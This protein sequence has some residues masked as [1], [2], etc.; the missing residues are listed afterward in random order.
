MTRPDAAR[1]SIATVSLSGTLEDKLAAAA[2]AGFDGVEIF[3]NDLITC[4]LGPS[5]IRLLAA[6]LGLDILLYQPFRDFESTRPSRLAVSLRRAEAKFAVM[7]ALGAETLL[8]CS[9]VSPDASDDDGAT[10]DQLCQLAERASAHGLRV[11]FEALAWGRHIDSYARAW[12]VVARAGHPHLGL[13]LDSF[14]ILSRGHDCEPIRDI[15][16][17]KI[18]FLQLAD[19][20]QLRMDALPWSRHYRCFPGQGDFDLPGFMTSVLAAGY[21]GP[22]SLEVFNDVFRQ[23][24]AERTARDGMRSLL[25][26]EDA[27][28]RPAVSEAPADPAEPVRLASLPSAASLAGYAFVE[29]AAGG[30]VGRA[31]ERVLESLG[32]RRRGRHRTKPV[33][34][35]QQGAARVLVNRSGPAGGSRPPGDAAVAALAVR[36]EDPD[37]SARRACALLAP[38]IARRAGPGEADLT[39]V[40]APDGSAIFFCQAGTGPGPDWRDDFEP[41]PADGPAGPALIT[42]IDHVALSQPD[43]GF[44]EAT[45]F[46]Q[47][48]LGMHAQASEEVAAPYGL[49]RSRPMIAPG[50]HVRLVLNV[51]LRGGGRLPETAGAQHVA[52]S[53]ADI[54]AAARAVRALGT[55]VLPVPANYYADLAARLDLDPERIAALRAGGVLYDRDGRGGEFLHFYTVML[56]RRLFFEIVQRSGGYDG[57]DTAGTPV[58]MAAQLRHAA[59]AG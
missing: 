21:R 18:F 16:G 6:D 24:D 39:A 25:T 55:P 42:G 44:D 27:L 31:A 41:R 32:F 51:P 10:A 50:G 52:F 47:A 14:H 33:D 48:L 54:F 5:Q 59:A 22:W 56:G 11:A 4:P 8:V 2:R 35:W 29:L 26:L 37:R 12:D 1:R 36:S 28:A 57:Y 3:E 30:L 20:P 43:D 23:A 15:P 45:L 17:D 58:R 13:C 49:V 40:D 19:A 53:C 7:S 46:Y 38:A 9:S 34:L